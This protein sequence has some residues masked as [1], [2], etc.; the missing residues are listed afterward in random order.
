VLLRSPTDFLK[1]SKPVESANKKKKR[2]FIEPADPGQSVDIGIFYSLQSAGNAKTALSDWGKALFHADL[3]SGERLWICGRNAPFDPTWI[4]EDRTF[5][6]GSG[7]I[8]A[9]EEALP[10]GGTLSGLSVVLYSDP[11]DGEPIV[12]A[13]L[14]GLSLTR[15]PVG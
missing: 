7:K 2:F 13:E 15:N 10:V 6:K 12:V 4:P 8:Y 5:S 3:P 1:T 14:T 11:K 9:D